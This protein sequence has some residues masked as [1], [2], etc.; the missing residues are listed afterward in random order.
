MM[1][2]SK[3]NEHP[4][5]VG[6][7]LGTTNSLVAWCDEAGPRILE[8]ASG[9]G[10]LPSV[11]RFDEEGNVSAIGKPARDHA[12]EFPTTTLFSIKR[13]M[14]RGIADVQNE[15]DYLPYAVVAGEHNTA[16][17]QVTETKIVSPQEVSAIILRELKTRAELALGKPVEKAVVTVPAYFDDAQRQATRD[18]GRIAGLDVV[19]IVNEPTAAALAYGLGVGEVDANGETNSQTGSDPVSLKVQAKPLA[20]VNETGTVSLNT[21]FNTE[22]CTTPGSGSGADTSVTGELDTD[23]ETSGGN[24]T[25]AVFDLGGGTF[26]VSILH[27][28]K[29]E[30]GIVDQVIATSGDTHLGGDDVDRMIVELIQKEIAEQLGQKIN[31]PPSTRQAFRSFAEATKIRLSN[32][33]SAKLEI[34]LGEGRSYQRTI[35]KD[36]LETMMLPWAERAIACCTQALKKADLPPEAIDRVIMVGGSTRIP[37]VRKKVGELFGTVPYTALNPDEVVALGAAVQ[38]SI[39]AGINRDM[40]LLDVIPLSLGIETLG[41]AVAKLVMS[42]TTIPAKATEMFTT[43]AEGQTNVKIHIL[44]GER[45]LVKDCRSLGEFDLTGIPPMPA[46]LPKIEVTFLVDANGVLNVSAV[47]KRSEKAARVQIVPNHGLTREEVDRME[48]ESMVHARE[49]MTAH[50]LIDLRNQARLDMRAIDRQIAKV[51]D[52]MDDAYRAEIAEKVAI[53]QKY[54][55]TEQPDA[56]AFHVALDAMD[57]ATIRLAELAIKQTL[58]D[59]S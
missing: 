57:K 16:R 35:T 31:F 8:D 12:V 45:E 42:N 34:D 38:G 40:L 24:S 50:Q 25:V 59:E 39:L 26:D 37:L 27:L 18:A 4:L 3:T 44:Q 15:L 41:G 51:G 54:V 49:D 20:Q 19:R 43:H 5:I 32:E 14:G 23:D 6:I 22:A 46:G 10:N 47:E 21:K 28:Q 56:Q 55:D 7:D 11:V 9:S 13:L 48:T 1:S 29:T 17:V 52:A 30:Q 2:T 53:V 33:Q 36:E 58:T